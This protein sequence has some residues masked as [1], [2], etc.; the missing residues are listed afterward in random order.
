M[1]INCFIYDI[2]REDLSWQVIFLMYIQKTAFK[3][4]IPIF[5]I[6]IKIFM[7]MPVTIVNAE[8][9]FSKI[10]LIKN[11]MLNYETDI[12]YLQLL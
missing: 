4:Y 5:Y 12:L 11:T 1:K 9:S 10:K 6:F 2:Q 8:K 3:G 7:T